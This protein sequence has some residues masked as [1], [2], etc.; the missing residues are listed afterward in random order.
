MRGA[1]AKKHTSYMGSVWS[2][3]A[4]IKTTGMH[5]IC[6]A[7]CIQLGRRCRRLEKQRPGNVVLYH[8]KRLISE[9]KSKR[10]SWREKRANDVQA[11]EKTVNQFHIARVR[12]AKRG[13]KLKWNR[14]NENEIKIK[15]LHFMHL[16]IKFD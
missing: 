11:R 13:K 7:Y 3:W 12:A 4:G 1:W 10:I 8:R 16:G 9:N 5:S 6:S 2:Q 15:L 14:R